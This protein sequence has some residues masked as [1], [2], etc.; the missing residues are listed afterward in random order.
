M[1]YICMIIYILVVL[2]GLAAII[3]E[4]EIVGFHERSPIEYFFALHLGVIGLIAL[5]VYFIFT[6]K[7]LGKGK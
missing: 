1:V 2:L 6:G 4:Q 3:T 5:A 7:I